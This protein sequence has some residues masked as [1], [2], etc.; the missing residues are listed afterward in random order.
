MLL[1]FDVVPHGYFEL[2][3]LCRTER[4]QYY[5]LTFHS[6]CFQFGIIKIYYIKVMQNLRLVH[7]SKGAWINHPILRQNFSSDSRWYQ[8]IKT[9][10]GRQDPD[11]LQTLLLSNQISLIL[12]SRVK[13]QSFSYQQFH[14]YIY[15]ILCHVGG[16]S[17]PTWHKIS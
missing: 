8:P 5:I 3:Y 6:H 12:G 1:M 15:Q 13:W 16:T 4:I 17:P 2:L 9:S 14:P 7:C 10:W 11:G